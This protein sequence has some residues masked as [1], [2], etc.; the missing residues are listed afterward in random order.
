MP[1]IPIDLTP[2]KRDDGK[3]DLIGKDDAGGE[4]VARTCE[5]GS[6]TAQDAEGLAFADRDR[7]TPSMLVQNVVAEQE[8]EKADRESAYE[9]ELMAAAGPVVHGALH[10][11][12]GKG[13][14]QGS[15]LRKDGG[16]HKSRWIFDRFGNSQEV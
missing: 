16:F 14:G 7:V 10:A 13:Y 9:D 5:T 15:A 6:F 11:F 3:L 2:R 4:Y 8:K 12:W 1:E